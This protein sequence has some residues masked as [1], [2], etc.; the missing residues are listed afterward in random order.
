[1]PT[2][3]FEADTV[4]EIASRILPSAHPHLATARILYIFRDKAAKE[5]NKPL[6]GE[7]SKVSGVNEYLLK[8]DFLMVI[9]QDLWNEMDGNRRDA[10]VDHLL[11]YCYGEEDEKDPGAPMKWR[12][13]RPD[14]KEFT[15]VL[16]R[17]GK[18]N[19]GACYPLWQPYL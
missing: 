5:G 13:R 12:I 11:T 2:T 16:N 17:R 10:L 9:A 19:Q 14:V 4:R 1:M 8:A 3:F 6:A 18:W 15:E 7:V